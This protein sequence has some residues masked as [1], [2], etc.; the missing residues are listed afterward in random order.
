MRNHSLN[1]IPL[2]TISITRSILRKVKAAS[3]MEHRAP[4]TVFIFHDTAV[5][6]A[7]DRLYNPSSILKNVSCH[8]DLN[9]GHHHK[10]LVNT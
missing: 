5:I 9:S 7:A 6:D 3:E 8:G 2:P 10:I 1:A 4:R